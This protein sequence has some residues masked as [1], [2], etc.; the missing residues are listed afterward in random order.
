M[1]NDRRTIKDHYFKDNGSHRAYMSG[2]PLPVSED[3]KVHNIDF[4]ECD[5]HPF[6]E[7]VTFVNCT[8][9]GCTREGALTCE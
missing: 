7:A 8:F 6:C 4:V 2:L 5:F 9:T 1:S 3:G